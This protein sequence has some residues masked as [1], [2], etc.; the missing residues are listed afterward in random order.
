MCVPGAVPRLVLK[1]SRVSRVRHCVLVYE[2]RRRP[3]WQLYESFRPMVCELTTA[4]LR[5]DYGRAGQGKSFEPTET[6]Y[7][8]GRA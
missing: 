3:R 1:V 7:G 8:A 2:T 6:W 4:E 5:T